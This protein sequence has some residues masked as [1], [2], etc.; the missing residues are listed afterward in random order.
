MAILEVLLR[1]KPLGEI[2][3]GKI[4]KAT[5]KYS[6][7]DLKLLVDQTVEKKLQDALKKGTPSPINTKDIITAAKKIKTSTAAWFSSARNYALYAN[8]GGV[9]DEI[10][11][12]MNFNMINPPL[13]FQLILSDSYHTKVKLHLF[14]KLLRFVIVVLEI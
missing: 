10:L 12:Y 6:G 13:L 7:A 3:Y 14:Q 2:D 11:E 1:G 8:E 9:Y 4:A 5:N